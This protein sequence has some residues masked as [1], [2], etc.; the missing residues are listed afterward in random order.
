MTNATTPRPLL[1]GNEWVQGQAGVREAINPA[2]GRVHGLV[3][4]ASRDDVDRAVATA[5]EAVRSADWRDMLPHVRARILSRVADAIEGG[6][7][8]LAQLQMRENGK[9]LAECR[10]QAVATAG[11]IRYYAGLCETQE[12]A[13]HPSRGEFVSYHVHEPMGVVAAITPWNSP[14][15][16]TAQKIGPALAAGNAIVLKPSEVTPMVQLHIGEL[17]LQAGLPAGLLNIVC[18]GGDIGAALVEHEGVDMVSFTG[19]TAAGQAIADA[20]GRRMLPVLLELGGKSANVVFDDADMDHAV[21]GAMYAIFHSGGQSC[22]AGSRLLVQAGSYDR[23]VEALIRRT[24]K[25][26]VGPPDAP[27]TTIGPMATFPHRDKVEQAVAGASRDGGVVLVGGGR[28]PDDDLRKGAYYLPTVIAG[29]T[30][31]H[32][33]CREELFAPVLHVL[34]FDEEAQAIEMANDSPYGLAAGIWTSDY[35]RALRMSRAIDAGT[36]WINT[37]K[38]LSIAAPFGGFKRSGL[39][40]EKGPEGM[41]AYQRS[42]SV[43]LG[44]RNAPFPWAPT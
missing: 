10:A 31:Q 21:A 14:M 3:S 2:D 26:R 9:T 35:Q 13:L 41:R 1:I 34:P 23:V 37:Y 20:C 22:I 5:R 7:E 27:N 17:C 12:D 25:I 15:T 29:L 38:E 32:A 36:I 18:G 28:P 16:M 4:Q 44:T 33:S 40:R 19:G 8:N 43:F 6:A 42:K 11:S 30:N 39:G 24:A